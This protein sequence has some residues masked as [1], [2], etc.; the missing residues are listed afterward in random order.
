MGKY[1][2][3]WGDRPRG[4]LPMSDST[5]S[6]KLDAAQ[7]TASN[8]RP[9]WLAR[10][11]QAILGYVEWRNFEHVIDKAKEACR[12]SGSLPSHH[13]VDA[14]KVMGLGGDAKGSPPRDYF[15]SRGAC[16]LIAM[17]AD[18]RNPAVAE[19]QIYFAVQTRRM[20]QEDAKRL[21]LRSQ[22]TQSFKRLSTAGEKAGV[23]RQMQ[24]A[25]HNARY[26][27]LYDRS[28]KELKVY[29]R[30]KP[31]ENL[32]DRAGPLE[33][34]TNDFSMALAENVLSGSNVTGE[35]AAINVNRSV[36]R[37]VRD[38]I[39]RSG[40]TLP[41]DLPLAPPIGEI[42]KKLQGPPQR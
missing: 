29:K 20:E 26:Q 7:K 24:G 2:I 33:L 3:E 35:Q 28:L 19:A 31:E 18:P 16:Y 34:A 36:A 42:R 27:G 11:L 41:E 9:Y 4:N 39:Q 13:F 14:N 6:E 5:I 32:F 30:L 37:R 15:L 23:R 40:G 1:G 10:D 22:V 38:T 12:K 25:F 8:D 17:N 21:R